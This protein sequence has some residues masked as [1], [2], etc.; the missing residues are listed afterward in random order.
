[1]TGRA[2]RV[3][4]RTGNRGPRPCARRPRG[5][6]A[7][8]HSCGP[9]PDPGAVFPR[10]AAARPSPGLRGCASP[11]TGR[12]RN[13]RVRARSCRTWGK[14]RRRCARRCGARTAPDLSAAARQRRHKPSDAPCR[15]EGRREGRPT[16]CPGLR[17]GDVR[18]VGRPRRALLSR[19]ACGRRTGPGPPP[20]TPAGRRG[21]G[22]PCR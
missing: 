4:C 17:A 9:W 2:Q 12:R 10:R 5:W 19:A 8:A 15:R 14:G 22:A 21:C 6:T 3:P 7:C 16:A 13:G 1:M 11:R 18:S 20:P